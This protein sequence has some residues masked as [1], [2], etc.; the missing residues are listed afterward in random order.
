MIGRFI[1]RLIWKSSLHGINHRYFHDGFLYVKIV[2]CNKDL[3]F[4]NGHRLPEF[5]RSF[6]W[7]DTVV[8]LNK[9]TKVF[10][11][12]WLSRWYSRSAIKDFN[13]DWR[14]SWCR[15]NRKIFLFRFNDSSLFIISACTKCALFKRFY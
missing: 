6:H 2:Y 4:A 7:I 11:Q 1:S 10:H 8:R 12:V 9:E 13:H 14:F 15:I 5:L 3:L